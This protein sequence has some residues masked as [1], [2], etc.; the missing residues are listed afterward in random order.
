MYLARV[1]DQLTVNL[2]EAGTWS[3]AMVKEPASIEASS[4]Q[5]AHRGSIFGTC[6]LRASLRNGASRLG[7]PEDRH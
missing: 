6:I 1:Q 4:K 3:C 5:F 2:P 7:N